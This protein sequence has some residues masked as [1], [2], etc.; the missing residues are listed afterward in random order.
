[1]HYNYDDPLDPYHVT[2]VECSEVDVPGGTT[3]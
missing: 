1:M 2:S 3:E